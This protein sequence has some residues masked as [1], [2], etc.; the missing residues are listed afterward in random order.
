MNIK[1]ATVT[2]ALLL[3]SGCAQNGTVRPTAE[4]DVSAPVAGPTGTISDS[5]KAA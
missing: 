4:P 5:I 1:F 3:A 2:A